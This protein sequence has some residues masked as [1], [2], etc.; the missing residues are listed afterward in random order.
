MSFSDDIRRF[1]A[2]TA[3]SH[4]KI[5][6]AATIELFSSVIKMTPVGDPDG[7]KYPLLAPPGYVGGRAR[8][9]WQASVGSPVD[10]E[11]ERLDQSGGSTISDAEGKTPQGAGQVTYLTNNLPYIER[12]EN[13]WSD[14]AAAGMVTVSMDRVSK[15]VAAAIEKNKV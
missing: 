13:G 12:L 1:T 8:G 7:W 4:N 5:V 11:V 15:I 9:N 2:K 10:G 14:Q 6:R 3:A